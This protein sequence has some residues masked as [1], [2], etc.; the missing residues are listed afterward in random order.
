MRRT[1]W[2]SDTLPLSY[3]RLKNV[4]TQRVSRSNVSTKQP[5][6][7][8]GIPSYRRPLRASTNLAERLG[9]EPSDRLHGLQI[10]NLL[11]YHPAPAP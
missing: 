3:T 8:S 7:M 1:D 10:S 2:K 4:L 11:H 6:T 9:V 5:Q